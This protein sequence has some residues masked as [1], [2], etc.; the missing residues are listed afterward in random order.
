M[1][2]SNT[3]VRIETTNKC[4][5]NCEMCSHDKMTRGKTTMS[6]GHFRY[7]VLQAQELGATLIS[8]F[9]FGEPLM[10]SDIAEKIRFC[11]IIGLDTFLTTNAGLLNT[12]MAYELLDAGLKRLRISAHGLW[13]EYDKVHKGLNFNTFTR[14]VF[15]FI[16]VNE[17]R[18]GKSCEVDVT[19]IPQE[20]AGLDRFVNFWRGKVDN[21]EIWRPHNWG[22]TKDYREATGKKLETCGRPFLG[23][24]QIQA[25]GTVIPCCFLTDSEI[26]LGDTYV[27]T[28][29]D[30][31]KG[32]RFNELRRKHGD[33]DLSGLVC[34]TCDQLFVGESPLLYSTVEKGINKTSSTKFNLLEN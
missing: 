29:E 20:D 17:V 21:I 24:V 12:N 5:A 33:K 16:K 4:Q 15:N 19:I 27:D 7:L 34:E 3:E 22:G 13:E 14:N 32:D 31:L 11:T 26:V 28:I 30:I 6:N 18:F 10:D 8:P 25:N 1:Q 2:L 9:G 23:P